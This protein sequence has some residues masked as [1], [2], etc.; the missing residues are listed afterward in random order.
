MI[1]HIGQGNSMSDRM[2]TTEGAMAQSSVRIENAHYAVDVATSTGSVIQFRDK[3]GAFDLIAEPRLADSFRVLLPLPGVRCNYILGVEQDAPVIES[4]DESVRMHWAGPLRSECGSFDLKV[5]LRI[6]LDGETVR[7]HSEVVNNTAHVIAEVWY[8]SLGG[9]R[10]MGEG[11]S[12]RDAKLFMPRETRGAISPIFRDFGNSR[13]QTLGVTGAEH[14]YCYPGFMCMPWV[15]LFHEGRGLAM[16]VAALE[17]V[18]RV[19]SVRLAIEPGV[20]ERREGGNW[21]RVEEVGD[22]PLGLVMNWVHYPYTKPGETFTSCPIELRCHEGNWRDSSRLYGEWFR[23]RYPVIEPGSTWI[24]RETAFLHTMFM[25]PEDNINLRFADVPN[26]AKE[27]KDRGVNHVMFAGWQIGGHDR[28]YPQYEPDPRLGT[29]EEL[30]AAIEACHNVGVR[31]SFFCNCQP[32]DMTTEWY[33]KELHKYRIMDPW[34]E[35]YFITNYWGMGT[36]SA[37]NRFFTATPNTEMNPA[38]PEVRELLISRF[39]KLVEI[40]ADGIHLDKFFQTPMDFNPRLKHTSPDRAHHEGIL[41]FVEE[42]FAACKA[43]NPE[44]CIS[45]EGG[46]DRLFSYTDTLWWGSADSVLK[47]IF[48]QMAFCAGVEQPYDYG[49]V[50]DAMLYGDNLLIGPGNY[51]RGLDYPPMQ[52]LI[53]YIKELTRIRTELFDIVSLGAREEASQGLFREAEPTVTFSG[54]ASIRWSVFRDVKS[55][56]RVIVLA[57]MGGESSRV[58]DLTLA[59]TKSSA[60]R[61][62]EAFESPARRTFPLSL[63]IP[64]ERV[65][66]IESI[67]P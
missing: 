27:A 56:R 65:V 62:H 54:S 46:W 22:L 53:A 14:A 49:K 31:A 29:W 39:R 51:N 59:D 24:R 4:T 60:C 41:L 61:V 36:L 52:N 2:R 34:G 64:P 10:G 48:P 58:S 5:T 7:F 3:A 32:I 11:E 67:V 9:M 13:G 63:N 18:P 44:F 40:G 21:P 47:E 1:R 42:L 43:I 66:F 35:Q 15:S 30:K 26:W 20:A 6:E 16:Y 25:L 17:D 55:G 37:R 23:A 28:G 12:G 57:N 8:A 45:Y 33:G 38:H 19:K 50:N